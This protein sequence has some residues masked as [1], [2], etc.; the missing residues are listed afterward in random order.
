MKLNFKKIGIFSKNENPKKNY[1]KISDLT[2]DPEFEAIY[3]QTE[4]NI[5]KICSSILEKGFDADCEIICWRW[6]GKIIVVDGHTRLKACKKSGI[7]DSV[8][9]VFKTF[10]SREEVI[11]FIRD[12]Q[13]RRRNLERNQLEVSIF[14][15]LLDYEKSENKKKYTNEYI[16]QNLGIK[17]TQLRKYREV[18]R[19]GTKEQLD[20]IINGKSSLNKIFNEIKGSQNP[21]KRRSEKSEEK[22][23]I[24]FDKNSFSHSEAIPKD[25]LEAE[26]FFLKFLYSFTKETTS[27]ETKETIRT[28]CNNKHMLTEYEYVW[29]AMVKAISELKLNGKATEETKS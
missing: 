13:N 11:Q 8:P 12:N 21:E 9:V 29:N 2:I 24:S 1:L 22:K 25:L 20:L 14:Q 10:N 15:Q 28:Y 26:K 4:F 3:P 19:N 6:N 27:E 16:M 23:Y 5:N 17:E 7:I 18:L